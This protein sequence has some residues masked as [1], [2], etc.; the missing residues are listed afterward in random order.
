MAHLHE[1]QLPHAAV[2]QWRVRIRPAGAAQAG[3]LPVIAQLVGLQDVACRIGCV[4]WMLLVRPPAL[5]AWLVAT[6]TSPR[7]C[8]L[9]RCLQPAASCCASLSLVLTGWCLSLCCGVLSGLIG[10]DLC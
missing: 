5:R 10:L 4:G 9:R 7:C 3:F 6:R 2:R 1:R 8:S